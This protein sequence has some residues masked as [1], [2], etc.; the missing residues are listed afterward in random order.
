MTA[1]VTWNNN[2]DYDREFCW[3]YSNLAASN[4]LHIAKDIVSN[5]WVYGKIIEC[6]RSL[7]PMVHREAAHV[8]KNL[9]MGYTSDLVDILVA[10]KNILQE[11]I[12]FVTLDK[13]YAPTVITI[14][15]KCLMTIFE[16]E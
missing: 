4:N 9:I 10:D 16:M 7:N 11:F 1:W 3:V 2:P 12:P 13:N 15:L 6:L 14:I 5:D 8:V